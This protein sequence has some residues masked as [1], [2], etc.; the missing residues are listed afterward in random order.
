M[1]LLL[2]LAALLLNARNL[3]ATLARFS[4]KGAALLLLGICLGPASTH[5]QLPDRE[6]L[7]TLRDRLLQPSDAYPNAADIPAVALTVNGRRLTMEAEVH[8]AIQT[9]V[10]L[11][12]RLPAWSP[13][14]VLIDGK[15]EAVLRR[16]DGYLWV[17]LPAG[18]H[19]VRV[20]GQLPDVTDWEWTFQL[21]PRHVTID[22]AGWTVSG[23]RPDG[24]PEQQIF[25]ALKQKSG[26]GEA[27]YERQELQTVASVDRSLELGLVWQTH[28]TVTRLSPLGKAVSLRIPLLPGENVLSANAVVKDG[29]IEARLGAHEQTFSWQSEL[30]PS[31]QI[32]LATRADDAW[33]ETW[34]LIASPIWNVTIAGLAPVFEQASAELVPVWH[35]WPGETADLAINRPEA[36]QGATVTVSNATH[37][38]SVG[39]RQRVSKLDLSLRCSVGED[40]LVDLPAAAEVTSLTRNEK[41]IPVRKDGTKLIVPLQPGEQRVSVAW[42]TDTLLGFSFTGEAV[43]LPVESANI[44]TIVHV[45]ENR[46]TLWTFGPV[47]GPAVRFWGILICAF[48]AAWALGRAPL[49]PLRALEWMLLAIGLT[50]VP[51]PAALVVVVWLFLLAWRGR[52]AASG[53][54][55]WVF[56]LLQFLLIAL[57][58]ISLAIFLAVVWEGLLGSPEMFIVG[59][60]SD[61]TLLRWYQARAEGLLP[62]PGF[63]SISI[64]WYRFLMLAWALWLAAALIRWLQWAWVQFSAGGSF[65][66]KK[67]NV[68]TPPPLP[69]GS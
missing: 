39:K 19:R 7:D 63:L 36:I 10:P 65:R 67:K 30:S 47:R 55:A 42:K 61:R 3:R 12:G 13:I 62:R 57:T 69:A 24:V 29:F 54:S 2:A 35:P 33:V 9:A 66:R 46:W 20:E 38:I 59:N 60:G 64:W 11:P 44:H 5:A 31:D 58:A 8:A 53:L 49:S 6:T 21:K 26:G 25:F 40:F 41:T 1:V 45:P 48:L 15:P 14:T 4:R 56:N 68:A 22:A 34:H 37:D 18:V 23:L 51:L 28:N 16:D 17:A 32:K 52:D 50:Q 27:S 43:R